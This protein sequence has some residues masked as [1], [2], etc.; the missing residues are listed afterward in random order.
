MSCIPHLSAEERDRRSAPCRRNSVEG[1]LGQAGAGK[2]ARMTLL[3]PPQRRA[4]RAKAHHLQPVVT[5]G[6]HGITPG[7]LHEIDVNLRAHELI[8]IRVF[9]DDRVRREAMLDRICAELDAAAVQHLGKLLIV[10]RP[11]PEEPLPD[12][13]QRSPRSNPRNPSL[14][15][16]SGRRGAPKGAGAMAK[17][18]PQARRPRTPMARSPARP[19]R[20]APRAGAPAANPLARGNRRRRGSAK[21]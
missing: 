1:E 13:V 18:K 10:W 6:Q 8:K 7:V 5:I 15:T 11:A 19:P 20:S 12:R 9:S 3:T 4:L 16:R 2:E 17:S 14:A 21:V